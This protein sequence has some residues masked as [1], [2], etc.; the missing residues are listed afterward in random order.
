MSMVQIQR[1]DTLGKLVAKY[2]R[3]NGTS[4]TVAQVAQANGLRDANKIQAGRQLIFPDK[5][6]QDAKQQ[7][8]RNGQGDRMVRNGVKEKVEVDSSV[9]MD[10]PVQAELFTYTKENPA[11]TRAIQAELQ[12]VNGKTDAE[13]IAS[14]P[15]GLR[16]FYDELRAKKP[17]LAD[18]L[19]KTMREVAAAKNP[20]PITT[21]TTTI[22]TN[23]Q[24]QKL[25]TIPTQNLL[26]QQRL[27]ILA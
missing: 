4:L 25:E 24:E 17:E 1:G 22:Q 14:A 9:R 13:L 11:T 21:E 26:R 8:I 23:V 3:E 18:S 2:N 6:E 20:V 7:V 27:D 5:F 15:K 16:A 12:Q 19:L 10:V